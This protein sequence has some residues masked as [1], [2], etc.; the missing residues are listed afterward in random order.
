MGP[1]NLAGLPPFDPHTPPNLSELEFLALEGSATT[2]D[3]RPKREFA[4][5][6]IPGA[7]GVELRDDFGVWVGWV[8]EFGSSLILVMNLEQDISEAIRQ[9]ARIGYDDIVGIVRDLGDWDLE[10]ESH[11]VV[12]VESVVTRIG[13]QAQVLDVRAPSEWESGVINGSVRAYAP[14]VTTGPP[15]GLDPDLP[16][17]VVCGTGYRASVAASFLHRHGYEPVVLADAGVPEVLA[18]LNK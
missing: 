8:T 3:A 14:E 5:G 16:V 11:E 4:A 1:S 13:Q 10:L 15:Q 6:H 7:I 18:V 12:D 9:L 17:I 2:I